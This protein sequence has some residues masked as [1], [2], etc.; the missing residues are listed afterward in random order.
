MDETP[1]AGEV[2]IGDLPAQVGFHMLYNYD[3][4]DNWH[5]DVALERI[6]PPQQDPVPYRL[7]DRHGE[8][9]EQYAYWE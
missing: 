2:R 1:S 9:P 6:E 3:F 7:G 8:S 4:G 5:F